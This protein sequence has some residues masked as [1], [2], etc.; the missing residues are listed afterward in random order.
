MCPTVE[1]KQISNPDTNFLRV[2]RLIDGGDTCLWGTNVHGPSLEILM[3]LLIKEC[4]PAERAAV[5]T[6][7]PRAYAHA[8]NYVAA[9][10]PNLNLYSTC[11]CVDGTAR[12]LADHARQILSLVD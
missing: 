8:S 5:M 9:R 2:T 7:K 4:L 3:L 12:L 10:E 6:A 11:R 1:I